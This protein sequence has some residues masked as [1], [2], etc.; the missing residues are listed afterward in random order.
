MSN[1]KIIYAITTIA[2]LINRN[3]IC[4]SSAGRA[5]CHR[6]MG[7]DHA[8]V[9]LLSGTHKSFAYREGDDLAR[10]RRGVWKRP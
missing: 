7:A 9:A 6:R 10:R 4:R 1:R 5:R 3:V 2:V 8:A